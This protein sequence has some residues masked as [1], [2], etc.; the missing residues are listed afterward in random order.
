MVG[1]KMNEASGHW[2][3]EMVDSTGSTGLLSSAH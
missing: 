3:W 1:K 2:T